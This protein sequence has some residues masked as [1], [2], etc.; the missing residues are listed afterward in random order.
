MGR[1]DL[2]SSL[3]IRDQA[4]LAELSLEGY[5]ALTTIR[6][7]NTPGEIGRAHV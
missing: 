3:T 2:L 1:S 7:K 5:S 6:I 4:Q